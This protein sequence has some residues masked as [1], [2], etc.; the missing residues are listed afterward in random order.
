MSGQ[1]IFTGHFSYPPT[2]YGSS[3]VGI[4]NARRSIRISGDATDDI[5]LSQQFNHTSQNPAIGT[6]Q[7]VV[8]EVGTSKTIQDDEHQVPFLSVFFVK[9]LLTPA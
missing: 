5:S 3:F 9:P 4:L 6:K 1:R 7:G 8:I 2:V